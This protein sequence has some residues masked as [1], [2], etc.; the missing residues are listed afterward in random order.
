MAIVTRAEFYRALRAYTRFATT[1]RGEAESTRVIDTLRRQTF[2]D[3]PTERVTIWFDGR[4]PVF[5]MTERPNPDPK[6]Y[7]LSECEIL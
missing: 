5:R 4:N 2:K 6:G 7:A 3:T 1:G